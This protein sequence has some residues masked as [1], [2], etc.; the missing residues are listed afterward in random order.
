[1]TP[2][3]WKTALEHEE[4]IFLL[5]FAAAVLV[6]TALNSSAD[7]TT[8]SSVLPAMETGRVAALDPQPGVRAEDVEARIHELVNQARTAEGAPQLIY[9][10]Q[11]AE[12][13][14]SHS[15]DMSDYK[16]F[17]HEDLDGNTPTDRASADGVVCIKDS[18]NGY[19][20]EDIGENIYLSVATGAGGGFG[21]ADEIA[22]KAVAELMNSP[23]HKRNIL[24]P[25]YGREGV[26]VKI[27]ADDH[28]YLTQDFC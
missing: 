11:L 9:D 4:P 19:T 2:R 7:I 26:G 15:S 17:R 12:S 22:E 21:S 14:R 10:A 8:P 5:L 18:D 27:T 6:L 16:Y 25:D 13:A 23:E 20:V 24:N 3:L 28:I 1:M